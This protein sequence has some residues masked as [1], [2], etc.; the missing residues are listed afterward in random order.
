[1]L[2]QMGQAPF[3]SIVARASWRPWKST[4]ANSPKRPRSP[5]GNDMV[6]G[7]NAVPGEHRMRNCTVFGHGAVPAT[8]ATMHDFVVPTGGGYFFT[9]SISALKKVIAG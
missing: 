1:M 5:S 6:I 7:Q 4:W 3:R 2:N 8:L 9:P